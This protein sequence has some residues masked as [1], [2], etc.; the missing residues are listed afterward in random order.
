MVV[1][2]CILVS[3]IDGWC[4]VFIIIF[5]DGVFLVLLVDGIFVVVFVDGIFLAFGG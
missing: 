2:W 5:V 1:S 3:V 4:V